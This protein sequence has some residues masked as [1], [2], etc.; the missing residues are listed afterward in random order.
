MRRAAARKRLADSQA[1][2]ADPG[3]HA[4]PTAAY[5]GITT[6]AVDRIIAAAKQLLSETGV[7]FAPGTEADALLTAAGCQMVGDGIVRMPVDVIDRALA[8]SPKSC[9]LWNRDGTKAIKIDDKH[10]WFFPG[11]TNIAIFDLETGEPR[12]SKRA[13]L[14]M[15]TRL[16][17][18]LPNIDGVCIS[19]KDVSRIDQYG[20][21]D[22]F[23]CM[24]ENTTKPLEYLC[25]HASSL[26]AVIDISAALRH[27]H[28]NLRAKPYFLQI[29]TPL[30]LKFADTHIEQIIMAARA[31]IPVSVGTLPIGGASTPITLAGGIAHSLATDFAAMVLAQQASPGAFCIGSS[32][33]CFMEPASGAIGSF[34]QTSIAD[35]AM[36]Q[37]R[38]SMGIPSLT[39]IAGATNARRFNQD[40]VWEL[41]SNMMQTFYSRPATCDYLGSLDQGLTYSAH[42]LLFCDDVAGL[43]RRMWEGFEVN[44]D[45]L[46]L[47]LANELGPAGNFLGQ[48]HTAENCRSQVWNSRYFGANMP[49]SN[50]GAADASLFE[51]IDQD[52]KQRLKAP[53]AADLPQ[54]TVNQINAILSEYKGVN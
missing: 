36:C 34:S 3:L 12:P 52:L 17:D 51:R 33:V 37:I 39:G 19:C 13:D 38:R 7:V 10:T 45:Q 47:G 50:S 16:A 53:P 1:P 4:G 43:L 27:G 5:A 14:A 6:A 49:R 54:E 20:E 21:I 44:D 9:T 42:A 41:S 25:E 31:G 46:A 2:V 18:G 8:R 11:M 15:I 40:A 30:P 23:V 26:K 32:D 35:L 29:I 48:K 24:I 28:T 22:E